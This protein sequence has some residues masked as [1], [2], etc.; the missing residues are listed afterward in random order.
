MVIEWIYAV[1]T[2]IIIIVGSYF[3]YRSEEVQ[4][5]FKE[6]EDAG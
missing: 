1:F 5:L 2:S 3:L 6:D 4:S